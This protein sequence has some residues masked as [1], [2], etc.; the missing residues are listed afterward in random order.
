MVRKTAVID[1]SI[2]QAICEQIP[3]YRDTLFNALLAQYVLVVPSILVEEVWVNLANPHPTKKRET[4]ENLVACLLHL[5]DAWIADPLDIS[6]AELVRGET[7]EF[8]PKPPA[9]VMNSFLTLQDDDP[10]L[11]IWVKHRQGLHKTCIRQ[12]VQEHGR[13]LNADASVSVV[14]EHD[15]FDKFIRP[16]FLEIMSVRSRK[17]KLLEGILGLTFRF[18]NP[19]Y[20][21]TIDAS[22][23]DFSLENFDKYPATLNCIMSAMFYFYAPLC[24]LVLPGGEKRKFLG[25]GFGDQKSNLNDEKYVQSGLLCARLITRDVGMRNVMELF[26]ACG[27]W[28]G[29]TVF[30]DPKK[31]LASEISTQLV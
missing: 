30:L 9:N 11:K 20:A 19:S 14:N 18:R 6:F 31:N 7:I 2:L 12:R 21:K 22:F 23:E 16:Q 25:R 24:K 3:E 15:V 13:I 27:L 10:A 17:L 4:F 26:R 29:Q 5:Q 8:L 28:N 1:K